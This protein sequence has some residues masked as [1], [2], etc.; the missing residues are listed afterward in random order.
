MINLKRN[1]MVKL[2]KNKRPIQTSTEI[3]SPIGKILNWILLFVLVLFILVPLAII[4]IASFKT[5][6]E[7]MY[8]GAFE[9]P[10]SFLNFDNY[11][12]VFSTGH[13]LLAY[14]NTIFLIVVSAFISIILNAAAAYAI[15]RFNFKFKTVV[16]VMFFIPTLV[17]VVLTQVPSF[18][19]MKDLHVLNTRWAG[20]LTYIGADIMQLYMYVQYISKIPKALDES[21]FLD[22]ASY[23]KIFISI[24]LPQLKPAIAT[25]LI[26]KI[27]AVYNDMLAPNLY[28]N[29]PSLAVV[30]TALMRFSTNQNTQYNLMSAAII[31]IMIPTL[32]VY[33]FLQKFIFS[34]ITDGAV[35]D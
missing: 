31:A 28:M 26:F 32:V 10:K 13:L 17:P 22:G 18:V 29:D 4:V 9:L 8:T 30:S 19:L 27:I 7:Y 14:G 23:F 6:R 20:I 34:G 5:N 12:T 3:Q 16:F 1:D 35:K 24:I 33:I 11:K 2:K 25:M 21:A 15:A